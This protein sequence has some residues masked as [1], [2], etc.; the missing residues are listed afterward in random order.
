[1]H[2]P[3]SVILKA[4]VVAAICPPVPPW[5]DSSDEFVCKMA[6][7]ID[8]AKGLVENGFDYVTDVDDMKLSRRRK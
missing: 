6:R 5:Q 2:V 7:T 4:L 8:D 1:M 3:A